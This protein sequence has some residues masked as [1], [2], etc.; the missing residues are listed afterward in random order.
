LRISERRIRLLREFY[1]I[2]T[3]YKNIDG[4]KDKLR[5]LGAVFLKSDEVLDLPE[6][7]HIKIACKK[8]PQYSSF[9]KDR[10]LEID[11]KL[12][13]GDTPLNYLLYARMLASQYNAN[14]LQVLED[15]IDS[16]DDRIIIFYNFNEELV[17]MLKLVG[18]RPY[19]IMNGYTKDLHKY[20]EY[21][22]SITFIQY[23]AG[24]AWA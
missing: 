24:G 6:Q 1:E 8:T 17:R 9:I 10:L 2:V 13:K 5:E 3:G 15:L 22:N 14:K 16:T 11:G 7:T 21:E 20:E 4:L 23:Q 18:K 12:L 19:S